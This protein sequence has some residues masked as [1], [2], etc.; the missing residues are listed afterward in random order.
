[1]FRFDY[2]QINELKEFL[3]N[4]NDHDSEIQE[5]NYER[6]KNSLCIRIFNPIYKTGL[7]IT[8]KEVKIFISING[9]YPLSR[10]TIIV[11]CLE[12][13]YSFIQNCMHVGKISEKD[14]LYLLF[15]MLSGD[16]FH[17]VAR[18]VYIEEQKHANSSSIL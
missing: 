16:E 7:N 10:D 18:E 14:N 5:I 9:S 12:D 8:F 3:Y 2:S 15:Q 11:I 4:S 1:M 6:E 13:D 17:I